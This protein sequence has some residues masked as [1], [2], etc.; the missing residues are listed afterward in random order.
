MSHTKWKT[1]VHG[2]KGWGESILQ[3]VR[4]NIY[5]ACSMHQLPECGRAS[6]AHAP[7]T[8]VWSC[9]HC[10]CTSYLSVVV[11]PL[12]MHQLPECGRASTAHAP[13]TRVWS[14][15]HCTCT[16]YLSVVVLPLHM[17]QLP[18]CGRASTA[19]APAT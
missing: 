9:F 19:H 10:T 14:C 8:R 5:C 1:T 13:A 17:H 3:V 16:S 15:F 4:S 18:E 6:T 12:H 11:L 2:N 7:A